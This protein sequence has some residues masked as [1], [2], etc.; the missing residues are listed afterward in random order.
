MPYR[1]FDLCLL[2]SVALD[3][4]LVCM[5]LLSRWG[6]VG[7]DRPWGVTMPRLLAAVT[8][9]AAAGSLKCVVVAVVTGSVFPLMNLV[10]VTLGASLPS[11]GLVILLASTWRHAGKRAFVVSPWVKVIGTLLLVPGP[12]AW[13]ATP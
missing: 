12:L 3:V 7:E 6:R 9:V 5:V 2:G 1:L 13:H 11:I 8:A 10:Y 4:L